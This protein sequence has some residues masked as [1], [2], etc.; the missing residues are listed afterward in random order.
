LQDL[1]HAT[2]FGEALDLLVRMQSVLPPTLSAPARW[3]LTRHE[4]ELYRHLGQAQRAEQLAWGLCEKLRQVGDATSFEEQLAAA[5]EHAAAFYDWH[6]F[7]EMADL[8]DPWLA[9]VET[10]PRRFQPETRVRLFNTLAR[11][12]VLLNRPGWED[13][14]GRSLDLL[15]R[16]DPFDLGRTYGYLLHGL[17]RHRHLEQARTTLDASSELATAALSRW[18]LRAYEA[19]WARQAGRIW[20]DPE[21]EAGPPP[22]QQGHPFAFYLQATA[23]QQGRERA[24]RHAR[25]RQATHLLEKDARQFGGGPL[26]HFLARCLGLATAAL[27]SE[28]G[29]WTLARDR[30]GQSL[31]EQTGTALAEYYHAVWLPLASADEPDEVLAETLLQS[32]PYT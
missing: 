6:R 10:D 31:H 25:F 14:F 16:R 26:L 15:A 29:E 11:A 22:G 19:E 23:R 17:L 30:L 21:M 12:R 32:I 2:Q 4:A 8:L 7:A 13:L 9:A 5:V 24:D 1:Y 20:T 27:G 28:V 3:E 18:W